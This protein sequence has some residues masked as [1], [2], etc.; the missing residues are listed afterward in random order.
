MAAKKLTQDLVKNVRVTLSSATVQINSALAEGQMR[1]PPWGLPLKDKKSPE[2]QGIKTRTT[3]KKGAKDTKNISEKKEERTVYSNEVEPVAQR[4]VNLTRRDKTYEERMSDMLEANEIDPIVRDVQE[5][6]KK[7]RKFFVGAKKSETKTD[8]SGL[9]LA[10]LASYIPMLK[11]DEDAKLRQKIRKVS[12]DQINTR[13]RELVISLQQA[14]SSSSKLHRLE[15]FCKHLLDF[16]EARRM[17]VKYGVVTCLLRMRHFARRDA[18]ITAEISEALAMLGYMDPVKGRGIRLL[19]IDGGGIRAIVAL[20]TMRQLEVATGKKIYE[21]FDYIAG[22]SAGSLLAFMVGT[23]RLP[24]DECEEYCNRCSRE[25]FKQGTFD[26]AVNLVKVFSVY[27]SEIWEKI[28]SG[29]MGDK[30]LIHSNIDMNSPKVSAAAAVSKP[31][32]SKYQTYLFRTYDI[33]YQL[34]SRYE[35]TCN[36]KVWEAVRAST[37]APVYFRE[38][39]KDDMILRDGGCLENNPTLI[40]IHECKLLWPEEEFQ[41]IVSLGNGRYEPMVKT[42]DPSSTNEVIKMINSATDTEAVHQGLTDLMSSDI[43]FRFNPY[44]SED[45]TLDEMRDEKWQQLR[46]DSQM[47]L[48]KND[49]KIQ[50]AAKRLMVPRTKIQKMK[51]W[52]KHQSIYHGLSHQ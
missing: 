9:N 33:P 4:T 34:Q 30:T 49:K 15:I 43:Y 44:M 21:L 46:H 39:I 17:S 2:P 42:G 52:A 35:G 31:G 32:M 29:N 28:L 19:T 37:A 45:L 48:R 20:E 38:V 11:K 6:E 36:S 41:C 3:V 23:W 13:T 24:L 22:V 7:E 51:D 40:A 25:L 47:Y 1:W 10:G 16:P 14:K 12:R 50:R 5:K 26:G 18:A 27:N 8:A